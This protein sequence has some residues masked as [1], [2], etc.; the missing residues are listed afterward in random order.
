MAG[1]HHAFGAGDVGAQPTKPKAPV[2]VKI[3]FWIWI[4]TAAL[5]VISAVLTV[6]SKNDILNTVRKNPP[7]G[8][9]ASQ[10]ESYANEVVTIIAAIS[11]IFAAFYAV[12]AWAMLKGKNWARITLTVVAVVGVVI[13]L[14]SGIS[15]YF[16]LIGLL[17]A[18]LGLIL[19]Y[20]PQ[21]SEFFNAAKRAR[22]VDR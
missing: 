14:F 17:L 20:L 22:T 1:E 4:V 2:P 8:L 15:S 9:D 13:T 6:L 10:L 11:I 12:M 5:M 7:K 16:N 3:A 21:S 18:L 19:V